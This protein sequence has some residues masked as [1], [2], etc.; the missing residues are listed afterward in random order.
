MVSCCVNGI[1]G[2]WSDDDIV[3][4]KGFGGVE[5]CCRCVGCGSLIPHL[6]HLLDS[7]F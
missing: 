5:G 2:G 4:G 3:E 6:L 1:L 7:F